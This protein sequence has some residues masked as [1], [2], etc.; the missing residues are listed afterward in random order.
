MRPANGVAIDP[1]GPTGSLIV[2]VNALDGV[3]LLRVPLD[4]S[5]ELS[6]LFSSPLRLAPI[7]I[8][9]SAVG[10]DGRIAVT[11]TSPDTMFRGVALLDPSTAVLERLPVAFDGDLQYPGW[12]RDGT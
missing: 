1:R 6:I 8:S 7:P 5:T 2:Q 10:P 12:S 11:V 4:G 9:G 3:K